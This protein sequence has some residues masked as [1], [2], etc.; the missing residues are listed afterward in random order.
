MITKECEICA[1][2]RF[3]GNYDMLLPILKA[4]IQSTHSLYGTRN[5]WC[6]RSACSSTTVCR[7]HQ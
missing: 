1:C 7:S 5:A 2:F 3:R 4:F 6:F